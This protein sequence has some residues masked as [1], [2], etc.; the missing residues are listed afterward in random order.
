MSQTYIFDRSA[1]GQARVY[2]EPRLIAIISSMMLSLCGLL[3]TRS[4]KPELQH[5][6]I[7]RTDLRPTGIQQSHFDPFLQRIDR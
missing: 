1:S 4:K 7:C 5:R 2:K 6:I 3:T